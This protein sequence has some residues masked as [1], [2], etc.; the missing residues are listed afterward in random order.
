MICPT[1]NNKMIELFTS[2]VCD[3]C[4]NQSIPVTLTRRF[5]YTIGYTVIGINGFSWHGHYF[6]T[7]NSIYVTL[8]DARDAARQVVTNFVYPKI[9]IFEV[10][11][12]LALPSSKGGPNCHVTVAYLDWSKANPQKDDSIL[13]LVETVRLP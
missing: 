9:D 10:Q 5:P 1:C 7:N 2:T 3:H 12:G 8:D 13:V 4:E 6:L 11:S